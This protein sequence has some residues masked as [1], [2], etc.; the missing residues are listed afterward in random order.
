MLRKAIFFLLI[1]LLVFPLIHAQ[2]T[3]TVSG[4]VTFS[5]D[6]DIYLLLK[7]KEEEKQ[8]SISSSRTVILKLTVEQKTAKQASFT[9][10][11]VPEGFYAIHCFQDMNKNGKLDRCPRGFLLEPF[12][13]YKPSLLLGE[14]DW[15]RNKF[16]VDKDLS[17]IRIEL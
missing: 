5:N 11:G 4:D 8:D 1:T 3:F 14:L 12:A 17:G 9:F 13:T 10:V 6:A 15:R 2:E 16:K 7:T